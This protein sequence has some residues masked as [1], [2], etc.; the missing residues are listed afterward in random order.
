MKRKIREQSWLARLACRKLRAHSVAIV[1]GRTIHLWN[2]RRQGF[3]QQTA[4]VQH[5]LAHVR[6]FQRYGKFLFTILYLW[7]SLR[8]GYCHN[9][10]EAEARQA[11]REVAPFAAIEFL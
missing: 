3:L 8:H 10:F 7:E 1:W 11:E 6:Q 2:V 5:E 9:R 4:W